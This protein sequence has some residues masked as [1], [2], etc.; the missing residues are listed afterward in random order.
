[1]ILR[2]LSPSHPDVLLAFQ[3]RS[4]QTSL[5]AIPLRQGPT[6]CHP[7][8][9]DGEFL[10]ELRRVCG[11]PRSETPRATRHLSCIRRRVV[12]KVKKMSGIAE[13]KAREIVVMDGVC[14]RF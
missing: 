5:Q 7:P 10:I 2:V 12:R 14:R 3:R 8:L 6:R 11:G 1:M 9:Q 13:I 4:L